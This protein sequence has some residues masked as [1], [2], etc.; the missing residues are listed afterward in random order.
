MQVVSGNAH[1]LNEHPHVVFLTYCPNLSFHTAIAHIE[2]VTAP[3][4]LAIGNSDKR[5]P[6]SQG[7]EYYHALRSQGVNTK[8]LLYDDD[9]HAIDKVQS[10][11]DHWIN[12]LQWFVSAFA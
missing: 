10:E 6:P 12:I 7:I 3:T 9:D 11:A 1:H 8:L 5:V 4:L 2:H